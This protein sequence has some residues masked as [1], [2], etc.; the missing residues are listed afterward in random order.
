MPGGLYWRV[1]GLWV[2][3]NKNYKKKTKLFRSENANDFVA[4]EM[5][6]GLMDL[7]QISSE[8]TLHNRRT[9]TIFEWSE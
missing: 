1:S 6:T 4:V 2:D 9:G 3:V 5:S 8:I 7:V